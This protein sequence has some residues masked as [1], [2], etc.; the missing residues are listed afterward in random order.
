MLATVIRMDKYTLLNKH[1]GH[2]QFRRGQEELIDAVLAGRG[3][4]A[5]RYGKAFLKA[6]SDWQEGRSEA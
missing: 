4:K 5:A 1:F 3:V 6:I 2:R